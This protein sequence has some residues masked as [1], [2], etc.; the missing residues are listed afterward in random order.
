[1]SGGGSGNPHRRDGGKHKSRQ[2]KRGQSSSND[3]MKVKMKK[4]SSSS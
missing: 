3:R 4:S 1:M 2:S